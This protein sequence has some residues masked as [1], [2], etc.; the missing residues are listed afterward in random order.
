VRILSRAP[1]AAAPA[2]GADR[3]AEVS[4]VRAGLALGMRHPA[5]YTRGRPGMT[6]QER[7]AAQA[8]EDR[9]QRRLQ[10]ARRNEPPD[11]PRP[12]HPWD[13]TD[14]AP[15]IAGRRQHDFTRHDR[16]GLR[17]CW[18]CARISPRSRAELAA[19]SPQS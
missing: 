5:S 4:R 9:A 18:Y 16:D 11:R 1:L 3:L 12:P 19:R 10:D 7:R 17:R 8:A 15:C 6:R 13:V 14:D 2:A